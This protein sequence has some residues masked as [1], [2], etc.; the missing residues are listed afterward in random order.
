ML[1]WLEELE[2]RTVPSTLRVRNTLDSGAGSLR[3][4]IAA[5]KSGD[6]IDFA[7]HL[8]GQTIT[9]TS[10]ELVIDKTLKIEG[11]GADKLTISGNDSNRVFDIEGGSGLAS[12]I[13][14]T[15]SGLTI[16]H[17]RSSEGGA[18]LNQGFSGLLLS[19]DVLTGD[20]ALGNAGS[21]GTRGGSVDGGTGGNGLGGALA[22]EGGGVEILNCTI[23]QNRAQGGAGGTAAN[24][25]DSSNAPGAAGGNGGNGGQ[26]LGGAVYNAGLGLA[27]LDCTIEGNQAIGGQ[28][29]A[30]GN[31]G[32]GVGGG[33]GGQ[34][35][36]GG[37]GE[38]GAIYDNSSMQSTDI[39]MSQSTLQRNE[40]LGGTGGQGGNGGAGIPFDSGALQTASG[41]TGG[42][43]GSAG[44]GIGGG[45]ANQGADSIR[46]RLVRDTIS[47]NAAIGGQGG[48]GG[49]GG[50][51]ANGMNADAANDFLGQVGGQGAGGGNGASGGLG[52]SGGIELG[53][54][55]ASLRD[56]AL[57]GNLAQGGASGAGGIG[58]DGGAGGTRRRGSFGLPGGLA[59]TGGTGGNAGDARGGGLTDDGGDLT[60]IGS[61]FSANQSVGG[62]G[63]GGGAAGHAGLNLGQSRGVG[64]QGTAGGTGGN[65]GNA[66][67]GAL[68]VLSGRVRIEKSAF[69]SDLAQGGA[70]GGGGNGGNGAVGPTF[71]RGGGPAGAGGVGGN[72]LGGAVA[73]DAGLL[74]DLRTQFF[75]NQAVGG[76]GGN[77]GAG[78]SGSPGDVPF[79]GSTKGGAGG[80]GGAGGDGFGGAVYMAGGITNLVDAV[81]SGNQALGGAAGAGGAGGPANGSIQ[82][83]GPAGAAGEAGQGLDGDVYIAGGSIT[84]DR[85]TT[86]EDK[87]ASRNEAN[88]FGL[89]ARLPSLP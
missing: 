70:G 33:A 79:G 36:V 54:A 5:A 77:G 60:L 37:L 59:G 22:N 39:F 74:S 38:G 20:E 46:L 47:G 49:S 64:Q 1:P 42:N 12:G 50:A 25:A 21:S 40:A 71:S 29:G 81:F 48:A 65:G 73:M 63:G 44:Q 58:G 8:R 62:A 11:L 16:T 27:I 10:G 31:G 9:L 28:G 30:G 45:I 3:D 72:G 76:A 69:R 61:L 35:G 83:P 89:F 66:I 86:H 55:Q 17:G 52:R 18:I 34:G 56:S 80:A 32:R 43:G 67:G 78:G 53:S 87:T 51:G 24:G 75:A 82:G 85:G 41:G 13:K 15:L 7:P 84:L 19:H 2:S 57:I 14:V 4:A 6:R 88:V 68:D 23:T 26:G